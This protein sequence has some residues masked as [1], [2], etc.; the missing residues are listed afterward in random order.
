MPVFRSVQRSFRRSIQRSRCLGVL[1]AAYVALFCS[2]QAQAQTQT[3]D[4]QRTQIPSGPYRIAGTVVDA[5]SGS[6]LARSRVT[7]A[8][9]KN[10]QSVQSVI[11]SD[12]GR[13]EF[14][15]PAGKYSLGGAKRGF[16]TAFYNQ[17]DHFSSAIVTGA[18]L[19]TDCW[20]RSR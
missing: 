20:G 18:D 8:S 4:Y 19:D 16:I 12:D 15:V 7:I 1:A 9:A 10:R 14:H 11:T 13:F 6:A 17:H 5:K 2:A 3:E